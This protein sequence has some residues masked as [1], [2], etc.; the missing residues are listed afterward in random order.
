[1]SELKTQVNWRLMIRAGLLVTA[2]GLALSGVL[3]AD[4][5]ECRVC[6][7]DQIRYLFA[8]FGYFAGFGYAIGWTLPPSPAETPE[9]KH[10]W[11]TR[12]G[13]WV[14][15]FGLGALVACAV[16]AYGLLG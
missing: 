14:G 15:S 8:T 7:E 10:T 6:W 12:Q 9:G 2:V 16:A 13:F 3:H 11:Q 4:R 5:L 1:M